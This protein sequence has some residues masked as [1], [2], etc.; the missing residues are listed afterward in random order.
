MRVW[1]QRLAS[2]PSKQMG[3]VR[4][5]L[6]APLFLKKGGFI[7][8]KTKIKKIGKEEIEIYNTIKEASQTI[9]TKMDNWKVQLLI[10]DAINTGKRAFGC[11]WKKI[12]E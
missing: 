10:A 1:C 3:W 12:E 5:P 11:N 8:G 4:I 2:L 6:P 7:M 9:L